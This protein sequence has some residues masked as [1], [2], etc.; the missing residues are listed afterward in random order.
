MA[1]GEFDGRYVREQITKL[2]QA[3]DQTVTLMTIHASFLKAGLWPDSEAGPFKLQFN[4]EVLRENPGFKDLWER[5]ISIEELSR[6]RRLQPFG[7]IN[8]QFL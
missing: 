7:I 4:E 2:L 8:Q 6:R 5:N 1:A 3:Y